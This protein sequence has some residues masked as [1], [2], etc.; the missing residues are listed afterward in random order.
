MRSLNWIPLGIVLT[1]AVLLTA[2]SDDLG[3]KDHHQPN[4][5]VPKVCTKYFPANNNVYVIIADNERVVLTQISLGLTKEETAVI[6]NPDK[7]LRQAKSMLTDEYGST[8]LEIPSITPHCGEAEDYL[9]KYVTT[10]LHA[11]DAWKK[12]SNRIGPIYIC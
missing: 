12:V 7:V 10:V 3:G 5:I 1:C 8:A 2:A 11:E 6:T 9:N 4:C